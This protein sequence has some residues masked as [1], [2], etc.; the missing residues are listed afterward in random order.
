[1]IQKQEIEKVLNCKI[2]NIEVIREKDGVF[3]ARLFYG[4]KTCVLKHFQN[5]KYIREIEM[6]KLIKSLGIK[7]LD[8]IYFGTDYILMEDLNA[9]KNY[10]LAT[11]EDLKNPVVISNLAKWYKD[12]H[13]KGH[14]CNL[15]D[16]YYENDII[17]I[18]NIKHLDNIL[19]QGDIEF[20]LQNFDNFM[21]LK[22]KLIYT[23]TYNDFAVENLIVGENIAFMYDYNFLGKGFVYADLQNVMSMLDDEN[24]QKFLQVYDIKN[25]SDIEKYAYKVLQTISSFIRAAQREKFPKW[26]ERLLEKIKSDKFKSV[27]KEI[28]NYVD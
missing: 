25:I 5:E 10:R 6:Y 21:K 1:M 13:A 4:D 27:V 28:K 18:E 15:S 14:D 11:E 22:N 19:S 20:L 24:K 16:L 12:L 17:T 8:I 2:K 7:T 9:S 3:V 23:L 26:A